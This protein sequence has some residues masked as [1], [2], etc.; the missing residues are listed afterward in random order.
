MII[1]IP[2]PITEANKLWFPCRKTVDTLHYHGLRIMGICSSWPKISVPLFTNFW[3]FLDYFTHTK[4][5]VVSHSIAFY[6]ISTQN[7]SK[8]HNG[9]R[10]VLGL[11]SLLY[12]YILYNISNYIKGIPWIY[13]PVFRNKLQT[14]LKSRDDQNCLWWRQTKTLLEAVNKLVACLFDWW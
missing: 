1:V 8:H 5:Y 9:Q 12:V 13:T 3:S 14:Q 6:F 7:I 2:F 10:L 11:G 4:R